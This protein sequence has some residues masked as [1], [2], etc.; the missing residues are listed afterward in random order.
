V[1]S[2]TPSSSRS[3]SGPASIC[4]RRP[5]GMVPESRRRPLSPRVARNARQSRSRDNVVPR[6]KARTSP[7][8]S[9]MNTNP[10]PHLIRW[11]GRGAGALC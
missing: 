11:M 8:L 1:Q 7:P 4:A 9:P 6:V 10:L 3:P 2:W 5:D